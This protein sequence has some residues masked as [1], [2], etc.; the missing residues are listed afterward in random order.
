M[1][2]YRIALTTQEE[3]RR[4]W[5]GYAW[6]PVRTKRKARRYPTREIAEVVIEMMRHLR[7]EMGSAAT[8]VED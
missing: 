7:P 4:Q 6:R 8:V 1:G 5:V 2:L 3:G